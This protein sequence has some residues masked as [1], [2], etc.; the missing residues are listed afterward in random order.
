MLNW[1]I[2]KLIFPIIIRNLTP[3]ILDILKGMKALSIRD[4]FENIAKKTETK[5]DDD[6]LFWENRFAVYIRKGTAL[7]RLL[8]ICKSSEFATKL[9]KD[10][11]EKVE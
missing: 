8:E 7:E 6:A 2:K 9:I 3:D 5:V 1:L 10:F 11:F 4:V